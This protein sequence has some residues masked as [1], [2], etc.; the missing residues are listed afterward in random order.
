MYAPKILQFQLIFS[1]PDL[2]SRMRHIHAYGMARRPTFNS[3][4]FYVPLFRACAS[5]HL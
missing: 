2:L 5:H 3:V 4:L 1:A